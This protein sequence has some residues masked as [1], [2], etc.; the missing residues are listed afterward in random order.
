MKNGQKCC[1]CV[2]NKPTPTTTPTTPQHKSECAPGNPLPASSE[3]LYKMTCEQNHHSAYALC[4]I[5]KAGPDGLIN[6]CCNWTE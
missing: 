4:S 5:V 3:A 6:C 1:A 2:G